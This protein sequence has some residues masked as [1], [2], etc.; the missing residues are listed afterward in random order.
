MKTLV[1]E[2]N[3][4]FL[5]DSR[6]DKTFILKNYSSVKKMPNEYFYH[7]Y[8]ILNNNDNNN[9]NNN[10]NNSN[11]SKNTNNV[12]VL[13]GRTGCPF[14]LESIRTLT[15]LIK[16]PKNKN[17]EFIFIDNENTKYTKNSIVKDLKNDI[18]NHNTVPIIFCNN[19][20]IG[21]NSD[22]HNYLQQI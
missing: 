17:D 18:G 10:N 4:Y 8:K 13:Y 19:K 7:K 1:Q 21:G 11:N 20:F 14:C 15:N 16:K 2:D 12:W 5:T 22:L 9:N 6:V 3:K